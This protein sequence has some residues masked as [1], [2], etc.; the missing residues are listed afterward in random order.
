MENREIAI[1][2]ETVFGL[3]HLHIRNSIEDIKRYNEFHSTHIQFD[4]FGLDQFLD[5]VVDSPRFHR[6]FAR[7]GGL[8]GNLLKVFLELRFEFE[9][10]I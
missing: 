9:T 5:F 4:F 3:Q 6:N 1:D 7:S 2:K 8:G 10:R